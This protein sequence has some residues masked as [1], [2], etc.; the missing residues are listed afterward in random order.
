MFQVFR[1]LA[2]NGVD[3]IG[4]ITKNYVIHIEFV[5]FHGFHGEISWVKRGPGH[6]TGGWG[7]DHM[8]PPLDLE[9]SASHHLLYELC[10]TSGKPSTRLPLGELVEQ[11]PASLAVLGSRT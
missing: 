7:P 9:E 6:Q 3:T 8:A 11:G 2:S 1:S 10:A 4:K 5:L